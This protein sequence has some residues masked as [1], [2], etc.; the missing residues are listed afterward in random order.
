M[1]LIDTGNGKNLEFG[2]TDYVTGEGRFITRSEND[3]ERYVNPELTVEERQ[4]ISRRDG[5]RRNQ[6]FV[7]LWGGNNTQVR[8]SVRYNS[9]TEA[10]FFSW[11]VCGHHGKKL[12]DVTSAL[13]KV[14][15]G[16]KNRFL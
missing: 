12:L 16:Y 9:G 10:L 15:K 2:H 5:N 13:D 6:T 4:K 14:E 3:K 11:F 8:G 7:S 1:T